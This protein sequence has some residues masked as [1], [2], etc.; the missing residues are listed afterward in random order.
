MKYDAISVLDFIL[1]GLLILLPVRAVSP[2]AQEQGGEVPAVAVGEARRALAEEVKVPVTQISIVG[3]PLRLPN[4]RNLH[5]QTTSTG[6]AEKSAAKGQLVTLVAFDL[7]RGDQDCG[8]RYVKC[9]RNPCGT[10]DRGGPVPTRA[11]ST[12]HPRRVRSRVG[13]GESLL[14]DVAR[15]SVR[16][17]Q[18][19]P[20]VGRST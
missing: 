1:S 7:G 3:K 18:V 14:G 6:E 5:K 2:P 20:M 17:E 4:H 8:P 16:I 15:L 12:L 9:D 19:P 10:S 11:L 13:R